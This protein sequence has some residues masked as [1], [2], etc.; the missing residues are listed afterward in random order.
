M[1]LNSQQRSAV[2]HD[3]GHALVLA[4]AGTGKTR[5]I[6]ERV[7]C[8]I[9]RGVDPGR[10]LMLTFTR[11][12]AREMVARLRLLIG[13][14]AEE[15]KAGTFH[16]F[17]LMARRRMPRTFDIEGFT[18]IDGDD[19]LQLMKL[20]RGK[21]KE[22]GVE[23]PTA[24]QLLN[25]QSYAR[26]T[27]QPAQEYL[28]KFTDLAGERAERVLKLFKDYEERKRLGHYLDFDD[29]LFR[30]AKKINEDRLTGE[31][32]R[33]L[34]DHIL[35]DEMQDTNP[36]QWLILNGLRDPAR[37]Y[38]VGDDAQSIY[39]FRGADFKNVRY[40]QERI[41]D[42]TIMRLEEN[43]RST[44]EI[45]DLAN[46]LLAESPLPYEKH[47]SSVRGAGQTPALM[48]FDSDFDEAAWL[49]SDLKQRHHQGA[50]WRDHMIIT[51]TGYGARTLEAAMVK[52]RIPYRFV[53]GTSL[54]QS[55]HVKDLFALVRC[56]A[57][58]LDELAWVR[59]LT[60]WPRIGESTA[61]K[62]VGELKKVESR[63]D[64]VDFIEGRFRSQPEIA[65]GVRIVL[66]NWN[67]PVLALTEAAT[68]LSDIL[69]NKYQNWRRRQKDFILLAKLAGGYNNLIN[70]LE[71]YTLDPI[72][73]SELERLEVDDVV[74]LITAHSAK[75]TE[76]PVCYL[77]RVE[78]GMYPHLRSMGDFDQQEEERR[79]LYV[80]MT[81]A[82]N[83]LVITRTSSTAG[84]RNC[85]GGYSTD[86]ERDLPAYFLEEVPGELIDWNDCG[87]DFVDYDYDVIKPYR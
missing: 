43:Y 16:Y 39:A 84:R 34:Y 69:K 49:A 55:A 26:N 12:A 71:A 10:I 17:C 4:G 28:A 65:L 47:L 75:G 37:L 59:Y 44:Q 5:T 64:A 61:G 8:L 85:F 19:Q 3:G 30:F 24:A 54:M 21:Y 87:D 15:M 18:V 77:I 11:R 70:F 33:S 35:V 9:D 38:C 74:T 42:S 73:T 29:I 46:W 2:E 76:S 67:Q 79:V 20:L 82:Q 40:F 68:F 36:L 60:L 66:E 27:N 53:G 50:P 6:I 62:V 25:Y 41:P 52:S 72:S 63:A 7:A 14:R 56:A 81:R 22:K 58:R 57:N 48:E 83:E 45:L 31:R 1:D 80:A 51:R 78:P 13:A 23:F 86:L 32:M